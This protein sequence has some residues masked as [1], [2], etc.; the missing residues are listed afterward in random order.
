MTSTVSDDHEFQDAV[1]AVQR[2]QLNLVHCAQ[3]Q[4]LRA[5]KDYIQKRNAGA[6]ALVGVESQLGGLFTTEE[7]QAYHSA[8]ATE[9]GR[10][11]R[12]LEETYD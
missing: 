8:R 10:I 12:W 1:D 9:S 7:L 5:I 6:L 2:E 4:L 3:R 11:L